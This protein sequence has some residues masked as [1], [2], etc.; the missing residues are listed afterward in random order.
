[1]EDLAKQ[2]E[3]KEKQLKDLKDNKSGS[4]CV[5]EHGS[6]TNME[7]EMKIEEIEDEV[8]ELRKKIEDQ[9]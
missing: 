4:F 2:L 9:S 6:K 7:F 8:A 1:M 5:N 3:E